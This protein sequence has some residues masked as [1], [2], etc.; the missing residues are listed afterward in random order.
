MADSN[1][2]LM[3]SHGHHLFSNRRMS[4]PS[5][6][7]MSTRMEMVLRHFPHGK[8]MASAVP[9]EAQMTRALAPQE[10]FC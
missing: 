2:Q 10:S 9:L 6:R 1:P 3:K 4:K 8:G 7:R 5:N